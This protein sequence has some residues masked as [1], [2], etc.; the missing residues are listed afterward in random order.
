[1]KRREIAVVLFCITFLLMTLGAIGVKGREQGRRVVCANNLRQLGAVLDMYCEDSENYYPPAYSNWYQHSSMVSYGPG[2][3]A[4]GLVLILPYLVDTDWSIRE[5]YTQSYPYDPQ[6]YLGHLKGIDNVRYLKLFW[7]PS[8]AVKY[9]YGE[10]SAVYGYV[11]VWQSTAFASFG[12]NQYC[13]RD[14]AQVRI[15]DSDI[16]F[17]SIEHCPLKN[18]PHVNGGQVS[19]ENWLTLADI[20]FEGFPLNPEFTRSNHNR[21]VTIIGRGGA[22]QRFHCAG[23][24]VLHVGGQVTWSDKAVMGDAEKTIGFFLIPDAGLSSGVSYWLYPRTE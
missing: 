4:K 12:Y 9:E 24:N 13:S 8:G 20:A 5:T 7:C 22:M 1:M 3:D 11:S 16:V 18:V 2:L 19:N 23:S 6:S 14:M 10:N 17:Q 21:M 15:G